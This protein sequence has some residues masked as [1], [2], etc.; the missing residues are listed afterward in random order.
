MGFSRQEYW[1]G[2]PFPSPRTVVLEKTLE[3]PLDSKEIN[4]VNPKGNEPWIFTGRADAEAEGQILW[5]PDMK[6]RLIGNLSLMLG[7]TEGRRR[8][9]RQRMRW[10]D[11][12]T[13]S[14]VEFR[15]TGRYWRTGNP[16]VLGISESWALLRD[17]ITITIRRWWMIEEPG[18]LQSKGEQRIGQVLSTE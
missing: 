18:V 5:P 4:P 15:Q 8:R 6:T 1:S 13:D 12:I 16:G 17:W 9:R 14:M 7:K 2:L 11:G 10:L 3:S